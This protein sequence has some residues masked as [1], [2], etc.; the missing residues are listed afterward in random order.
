MI[1]DPESGGDIHETGIINDRLIV[2][3]MANKIKKQSKTPINT[4]IGKEIAK[5]Y[6]FEFFQQKIR[7]PS[8]VSKVYS[9]LMCDIGKTYN[10]SIKNR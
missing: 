5:P 6:L 9:N 4:K 1:Y 10:K 3:L 7:R 8:L 2:S